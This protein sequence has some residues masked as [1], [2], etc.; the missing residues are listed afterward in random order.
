MCKNSTTCKS[1]SLNSIINKRVL[2]LTDHDR[3]AL[4]LKVTNQ[5]WSMLRQIASRLNA[6]YSGYNSHE[7]VQ[8]HRN[9]CRSD[10]LLRS[11]ERTRFVANICQMFLDLSM[12]RNLLLRIAL[13]SEPRAQCLQR[14]V[15]A[16]PTII[17]ETILHVMVVCVTSTHQILG[18]SADW[19]TE[20]KKNP[21]TFLAVFRTLTLDACMWIH[22]IFAFQFVFM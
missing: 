15:S 2:L 19:W 1:I 6:Q 11:N 16:A 17:I 8:A 3:S 21:K 10:P 5:R 13:P 14:T 7:S 20:L 22:Q 12:V 18:S 4:S 9:L